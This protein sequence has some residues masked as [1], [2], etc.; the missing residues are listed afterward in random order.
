M[1]NRQVFEATSNNLVSKFLDALFKVERQKHTTWSKADYL[2]VWELKCNECAVEVVRSYINLNI[3]SF[4]MVVDS[5]AEAQALFIKRINDE[6]SSFAFPRLAI[7]SQATSNE[8]EFSISSNLACAES[9]VSTFSN[10]RS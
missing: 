5:F 10:V 3:T 4:F 6:S 9:N 8:G 1:S 7:F 2:K